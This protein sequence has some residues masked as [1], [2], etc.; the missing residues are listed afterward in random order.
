MVDER[1]L[2]EEREA[3]IDEANNNKKGKKEET[4]DSQRVL[5][6]LRES[7]ALPGDLLVLTL[8]YLQAQYVTT[9]EAEALVRRL[10]LQGYH[11]TGVHAY[12]HYMAAATFATEAAC[13]VKRDTIPG[14]SQRRNR[15]GKCAVS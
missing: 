1:D 10:G 9:K 8:A 11:E 2:A 13:A 15:R 6:R 12:K 5:D 3:A 7:S 14:S 4:H